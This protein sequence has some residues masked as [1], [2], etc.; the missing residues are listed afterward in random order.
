VNRQRVPRAFQDFHDWIASRLRRS[1]NGHGWAEMLLE[2]ASGSE[3]VAFEK[4]W[5]ELD[6]FRAR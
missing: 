6:A 5:L 4:F 3:E 2:A 1:K